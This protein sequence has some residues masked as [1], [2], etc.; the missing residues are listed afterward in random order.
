MTTNPTNNSKVAT[1]E[2]T[3][4]DTNKVIKNSTISGTESTISSTKSTK[5]CTIR[6]VSS[7]SGSTVASF[8][9]VPNGMLHC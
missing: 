3:T 1:R 2:T 4:R 8:E 9:T 6:E 5:G 7:L